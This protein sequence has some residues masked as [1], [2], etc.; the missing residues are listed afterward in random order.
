MTN[1]KNRSTPT[2]TPRDGS[3]P[4]Q[5]PFRLRCKGNPL[6]PPRNEEPLAVSDGGQDSRREAL[7]VK[8]AYSRRRGDTART[9][10]VTLVA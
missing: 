6:P 5:R 3:T 4:A 7:C 1:T 8:A 2:T 10:E 9:G